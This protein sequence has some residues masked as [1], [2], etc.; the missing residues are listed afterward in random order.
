MRVVLTS[1]FAA[2]AERYH[3][4]KRR[5]D[6]T[7]RLATEDAGTACQNRCRRDDTMSSVMKQAQPTRGHDHAIP[8]P[9]LTSNYEKQECGAC[10]HG[11]ERV[12]CSGDGG[13]ADGAARVDQILDA[14]PEH[15]SKTH[16]CRWQLAEGLLR[17]HMN[18][19]GVTE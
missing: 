9:K 15:E 1:D 8:A 4:N 16:R 7:R 14:E 11:A 5:V 18:G 6:V 19:V 2:E 3:T 10:G 17:G 13:V 12:G